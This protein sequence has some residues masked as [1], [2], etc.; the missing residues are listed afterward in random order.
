VAPETFLA[1]FRGVLL[2]GVALAL[3]ALMA[4]AFMHRRGEPA[5][6]A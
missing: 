5:S 1:G 4:V 3:A 2:I 6:S